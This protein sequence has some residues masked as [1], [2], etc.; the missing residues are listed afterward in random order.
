[1]SWTPLFTEL[2][3]SS[4]WRL[5]SPTRL[6]WIT[7]LAKKHYRTHKIRT[8]P[9]LL[10]EWARITTEE[11]ATA[12]TT[13]L[14]PD[15]SSLN[16][17]E[18]GRRIKEVGP[19]EY[20]VI[21]GK[22]YADRMRS[23]VDREQARRRM[24]TLRASRAEPE[25][26]DPNSDSPEVPSQT[27]NFEVA[28]PIIAYLNEKTG[29]KFTVNETSA[30]LI[31]ARLKLPGVTVEGIKQMINRQVALWTGDKMEEYLRPIT[32]FGKEKFDGYYAAKDQPV[33]YE[34]NR[35]TGRPL[36]GAEQRRAFCPGH[37]VKGIKSTIGEANPFYDPNKS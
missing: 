29:K 16:P 10:A 24:Q 14:S 20:L 33:A 19:N 25:D 36:T 28:R 35:N 8:N 34:S 15:P 4:V 30:A 27:K 1:M 22:V 5:P 6:A 13:F 32:L 3:D 17:S 31:A 18:E 11:A 37:D 21:N 23:E 9:S 2:V 26:D 12:L 7:I